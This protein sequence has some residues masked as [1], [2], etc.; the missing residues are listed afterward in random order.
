[1]T[2]VKKINSDWQPQEFPEAQVGDVVDFPGPIDSLVK[3]GIVMPCDEKGNEI[4]AYDSLN[5]VT[6]KEL[7][8]FR[9][10]RK[11]QAQVSLKVT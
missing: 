3:E 5:I 7:N 4:S 8:D 10:W 2:W 6:E 11:Q 1:M 9:E